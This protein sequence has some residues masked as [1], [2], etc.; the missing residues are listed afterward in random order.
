LRSAKGIEWTAVLGC[1]AAFAALT[2]LSLTAP[3][4]AEIWRIPGFFGLGFAAGLLNTAI[5]HALSIGYRQAPAATVNLAGLFFGL[6]SLLVTLMIV[7]HE[8]KGPRRAQCV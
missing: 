5:F 3:P 8:R 4:V 7:R 1:I 2:G 6:G